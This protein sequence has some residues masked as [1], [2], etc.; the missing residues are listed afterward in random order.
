MHITP[1]S[2]GIDPGITSF[3]DLPA[4]WCS[5][6]DA[7]ALTD[8]P[9][10]VHQYGRVLTV[11]RSLYTVQK[12]FFDDAICHRRLANYAWSPWKR[13]ATAEPPTVNQFAF[14]AGWSQRSNACRYWRNQEN[15][16]TFVLAAM[17]SSVIT[18]GE[19][20]CTFPTGYRISQNVMKAAMYTNFDGSIETY[21][22][23]GYVTIY[24]N[25]N[26]SPWQTPATANTVYADLSFVPTS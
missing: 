9:P 23:A 6:P 12:A 4:G 17:K 5:V 8:R 25:G 1:A 15:E 19:I 14:A 24:S 2:P 21:L 10:V 11:R 16:M 7:T 20:I 13:L 22:G 18:N 3:N 26:I